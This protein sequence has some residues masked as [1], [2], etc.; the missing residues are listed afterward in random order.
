[1]KQTPTMKSFLDEGDLTQCL[2]TGLIK[3]CASW[4]SSAHEIKG[5]T[6]ENEGSL[7]HEPSTMS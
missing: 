7:L 4:S 2:L 5:K 1:M 6:T 3:L